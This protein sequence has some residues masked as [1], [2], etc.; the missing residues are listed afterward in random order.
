MAT[1]EDSLARAHGKLISVQ[2]ILQG[3]NHRNKNQHRTSK[4]WAQFDMLRRHTQKLAGELRQAVEAEAARSR[5][6]TKSKKTA[7][8]PTDELSAVKARARWLRETYL[9]QVYL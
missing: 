4:W 2:P 8:K 1:T 6:T 3:F 9:P 7:R 5:S